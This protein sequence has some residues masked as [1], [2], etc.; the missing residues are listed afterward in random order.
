M[1]DVLPGSLAKR[2][3]DEKRNQAHLCNLIKCHMRINY[4]ARLNILAEMQ[5][6]LTNKISPQACV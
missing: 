3:Y 4:H 1:Y 5:T 6:V 2:S